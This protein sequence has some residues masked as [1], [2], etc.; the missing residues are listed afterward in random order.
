MT[1]AA[2]LAGFLFLAAIPLAPAPEGDRAAIDSSLEKA[3]AWVDALRVDPKALRDEHGMRGKKYLTEKLFVYFALATAE[4]DPGKR[5]AIVEKF[6]TAFA[7][8]ADPEFHAFDDADLKLFREEAMSYLNALY[9]ASRLGLADPAHGKSVAEKQPAIAKDLPNRAVHWQM[10]FV[11]LLSKLGA[12][13]PVTLDSLAPKTILASRRATNGLSTEDTYGLVHE[14][15]VLASY[16]E[17]PVRWP[18]P[19][20][21][22]YAQAA[23]PVLVERCIRD[24]DADLLAEVLVAMRFSG[25]DSNT[26]FA[27]GVRHLLTRQNENGSFG[28]YERRRAELL[29]AKSRF[30]VDVGGY[31][32]TTEVAIWALLGARSSM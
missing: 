13:P 19:E 6:K 25:F 3:V 20:S 23:L 14:I 22:L 21:R 27:D 10:T 12:T 9:L 24:N 1:L 5:A 18:T 2:A 16:G 7:P 28:N 29:R 11:F 17:S 30:D 15:S 31:L 8:A 26:A 32:H 4:K